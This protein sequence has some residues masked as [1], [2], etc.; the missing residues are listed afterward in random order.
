MKVKCV[1]L[2]VGITDLS[3]ATVQA[4]RASYGQGRGGRPWARLRLKVL[5][6]DKHQCQPCKRNGV[7]SRA[8]EVDHVLPVSE[9]GT[10]AMSN[11]QGICPTCHKAK[12]AAEQKRGCNR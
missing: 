7:L 10:D 9:G 3:I 5:E 4:P 8:E 11:L 6:R 1:Q 2:G 12:T